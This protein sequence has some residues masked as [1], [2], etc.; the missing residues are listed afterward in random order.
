[1]DLFRRIFMSRN[2]PTALANMCWK[3]RMWTT[4]KIMPVYDSWSPICICVSEPKWNWKMTLISYPV[5]LTITPPAHLRLLYWLLTS[6]HSSW[7]W[8]GST[9]I[10]WEPVFQINISHMILSACRRIR[11]LILLDLQNTEHYLML[12]RYFCSYSFKLSRLSTVSL[13]FSILTKNMMSVL[14]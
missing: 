12:L 7:Y 11:N 13:F 1:M 14:C 3:G 2:R 6:G 9:L 4:W 8:L 5:K 10:V